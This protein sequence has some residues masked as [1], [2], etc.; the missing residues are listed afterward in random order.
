MPTLPRRCAW[1]SQAWPRVTG[2]RLRSA[3]PNSRRTPP[4][5][6]WEV[7]SNGKYSPPVRVGAKRV[8]SRLEV[9]F[10]RRSWA[11]IADGSITV[12]YRR[13]KRPQAVAGHHYR[14]GAGIIEV[15]TVDIVDARAITDVDARRAGYD[16]AAAL[17]VD[18]RGTEDVPIYRIG[19]RLVQEP[20]PRT[21]L[22]A[23]DSL[24]AQD[25]T[26]I[27]RRLDRLD[28]AS[29]RGPW[30]QATLAVIAERP[31]VRAA[32]L[33][34]SLGRDRHSFKIDVRKL[35]NLGLTIS[36]EVGYRLSPR[37]HAYLRRTERRD[38]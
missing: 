15:E 12:T 10:Q 14:T 37:G 26:E 28:R 25:F 36:L 21:Q 23:D 4:N 24:G 33:A 18:L 31:A 27:D 6:R 3:P 16:N 19:S 13:W 11:G 2:P 22:A 32:D 8:G 30:T 9:L 5:L 20:D 35:K 17:I 1:R 34:A 38:S 7:P 29:P